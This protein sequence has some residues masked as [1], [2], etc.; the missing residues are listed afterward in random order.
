MQ[1]FKIYYRWKCK[2]RR[3]NSIFSILLSA[4]YRGHRVSSFW[5]IFSRIN[6]YPLSHIARPSCINL[7]WPPTSCFSRPWATYTKSSFLLRKCTDLGESPFSIDRS[8]TKGSESLPLPG[9][10]DARNANFY[11]YIFWLPHLAAQFTNFMSE[12]QLVQNYIMVVDACFLPSCNFV[13]CWLFSKLIHQ[14]SEF[15]M[16]K[17]E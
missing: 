9:L 5:N 11:I 4:V 17:R 7:K 15:I 3:K 12:C 1:F 2:F 14:A 16:R 10:P 6:C 13:L 8:M